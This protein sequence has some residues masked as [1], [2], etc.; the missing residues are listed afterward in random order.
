MAGRLPR[1]TAPEVVRALERAGWRRVT[2][3]GSHVQ[4]KHAARGRRV[5]VPMHRGRILRLGTLDK[6][7]EQAEL[8][9]EE[10]KALL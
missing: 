2:Q 7:L 1:V 9:V 6:I 4:L 10:F 5:T 8:S 3:V